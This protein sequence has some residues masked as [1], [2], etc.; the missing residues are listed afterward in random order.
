MTSVNRSGDAVEQPTPVF[1]IRH[2]FNISPEPFSGSCF[3]CALI[4]SSTLESLEVVFV[5]SV[6]RDSA[7]ALHDERRDPASG[8]LYVA[9]NGKFSAA[10]PNAWER[11]DESETTD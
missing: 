9:C 2:G 1:V 6:F 8:A 10:M 5:H 7:I 11:M 4:A 3:S